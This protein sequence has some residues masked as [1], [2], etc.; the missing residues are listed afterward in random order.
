MNSPF[1][2]NAPANRAPLIGSD[3]PPPY[4]VI[5]EGGQASCL[6]ICD[7]AGAA[8]PSALN[9]LGLNDED[10]A[11]HYARDI[12]VDRVTRTLSALMDA[13]AILSNYSRLVVDLNRQLDHPTAFVTSG[14]GK[15]IPGNVTMSD[16]DRAARVAEIYEP[17]H[18]EI[19]RLLDN[20][21]RR[22]ICP[23]VISVHSFTRKFFQQVRPWEVGFLWVQDERLPQPMIK[24]FTA[25]GY[26]VGDNEPY[27]ARI[28]RGTTIN[29][30]AD[31]RGLANVLLEIRNDLIA[32]DEQSDHWAHLLHDCLGELLHNEA[33]YTP[34]DGPCLTDYDPERERRYFEELIEHAKKGGTDQ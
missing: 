16:A 27:D 33:L 12:G 17:Y 6:L 8:V 22:G 26:M 32:N 15:P 23:I 30:H 20:F 4:T 14:D 11:R 24:W 1:S 19:E 5:N 29:R 25:R 7:H 2:K 18:A 28:V 31:G 9:Q 34:Y 21:D 13:P 3:E 10:Y